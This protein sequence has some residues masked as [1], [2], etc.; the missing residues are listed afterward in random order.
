ML[1]RPERKL[2]HIRSKKGRPAHST[3][4]VAS[5]SSIQ[6]RSAGRHQPVHLE[7]RHHRPHGE[8]EEG[9]G[10]G[11]GDAE[12][13]RHVLQLGVRL[14]GR[15][16]D[17]R[18]EGH[19][20]DGTRP[21]ASSPGP[22]GPSGRSTRRPRPRP[23]RAGGL[24]VSHR[25]T[26]LQERLRV[27]GEPLPAA[28]V[29]EVVRL[30]AVL[31]RPGRR[32]GVDLHPADG[33]G[34]HGRGRAPEI[35]L[36]DPPRTSLDTGGCRSG[37]SPPRAR[38][39]RPAAEAGS[40]NIPQTGSRTGFPR[41]GRPRVILRGLSTMLSPWRCERGGRVSGGEEGGE[42]ADASGNGREEA[43]FIDTNGR[44]QQRKVR[45][46]TCRRGRSADYLRSITLRS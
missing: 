41:P 26:G 33:V 31:V 37:R 11:N 20:A 38:A 16:D 17:P 46:T 7:R 4:G 30:P 13:T 25:R 8:D 10:E 9:D 14:L 45:G 23:P 32:R 40:T 12:A 35:P 3:T 36:A 42:G 34:L 29:A 27:G 2:A 28:R 18:L 22:P 24:H 6:P 44:A 19:P 43:D 1:R 21:R 15:G 39:S 5:S